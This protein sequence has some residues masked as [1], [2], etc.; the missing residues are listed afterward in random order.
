MRGWRPDHPL[1]GEARHKSNVRSYANVYQ[2]RGHLVPQPCAEC[3]AK[4]EKHH[5]DYGHP[6]LVVWLCRGHHL[7]RHRE[8]QGAD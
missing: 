2:H 1:I 6:L 3:G 7:A 5:P 8:A 4:A